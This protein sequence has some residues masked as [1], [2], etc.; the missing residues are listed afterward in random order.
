MYLHI[1]SSWIFE[2]EPSKICSHLS[3]KGIKG[4]FFEL[5]QKITLIK[6]KERK[7]RNS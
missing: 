6:G 4:R 1:L 2:D 7:N 5:R 3:G